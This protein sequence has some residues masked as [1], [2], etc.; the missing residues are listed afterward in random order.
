MWVQVYLLPYLG[1]QHVLSW[2]EENAIREEGRQQINE[3]K[4]EE[5]SAVWPRWLRN[6]ASPMAHLL[7]PVEVFLY[8]DEELGIGDKYDVSFL[9]NLLGYARRATWGSDIYIVVGKGDMQQELLEEQP[10]RSEWF[11][12]LLTQRVT[13]ILEIKGEFSDRK[14]KN[15]SALSRRR[16]KVMHSLFSEWRWQCYI[17]E[18]SLYRVG[19]HKNFLSSFITND[20]APKGYNCVLVLTTP[21]SSDHVGFIKETLKDYPKRKFLVAVVDGDEDDDGQS[22]YSELQIACRNR[23]KLVACRSLF[24]LHYLLQKLNAPGPAYSQ[25]NWA[26]Q[27]ALTLD[28]ES[29]E[30]DESPYLLITHSLVTDADSRFC[31]TAAA[32]VH[33]IMESHPSLS[34][35]KLLL[36]PAVTTKVL[37]DVLKLLGSR[38]NLIWLHLG[39][40]EIVNEAQISN[41]EIFRQPEDWLKCFAA[42]EGQ[43]VMVTFIFSESEGM[44]YRFAQGPIGMTKKLPNASIGFGK[45]VP[46]M[47]SRFLTEKVIPVAVQTSGNPQSI[48]E[49]F[50]Q[51]RQLLVDEYK[52]VFPIYLSLN[53]IRS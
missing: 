51:V 41:S 17:F 22:L 36:Y 3:Q 52:E 28:V 8:L 47:A 31:Y 7:H 2:V 53:P 37:P 39:H 20:V 26:E 5:S 30:K 16:R 24:E 32:E 4:W 13:D 38:R 46:V 49:V 12:S 45:E 21:L 27:F 34:A 48:Q 11:E 35:A 9:A 23:C 1:A 44:A 6:N 18:P 42:Y 14:L 19:V 29:I 50:E 10:L 40:G 43:L 33:K 15:A 25:L